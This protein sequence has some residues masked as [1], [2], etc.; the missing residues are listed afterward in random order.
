MNLRNRNRWIVSLFLLFVIGFTALMTFYAGPRMMKLRDSVEVEAYL[1]KCQ[2]IHDGNRIDVQLRSAQR[3]NP[4][5]EIP[6]RLAGLQSPPRLPA[7]DPELILWAEV[8]QIT[9]ARAAMIGESAHQTLLAFIR[10]QNL[11]LERADGHPTTETLEPG[12]AVHVISAGSRL[13]IKQLENGLA[14]HVPEDLQQHSERY[15]QAE[16]EARRKQL[17]LWAR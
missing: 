7:D 15:A 9:P 4:H 12:T 14:V 10:K 11:R 8:H 6:V 1:Y 16:E 3:P 13:G 17:G 5:P 2:K